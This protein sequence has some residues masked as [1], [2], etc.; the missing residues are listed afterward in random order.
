MCE[1]GGREQ[2]AALR[3]CDAAAGTGACECAGGIGVSVITLI[4]ILKNARRAV[5]LLACAFAC[6]YAFA[7]TTTSDQTVLVEKSTEEIPIPFPTKDNLPR[8]ISFDA[9]T[10]QEVQMI[11][12]DIYNHPQF[13][14]E[15]AGKVDLTRPNC[16]QWMFKKDIGKN[17][18]VPIGFFVNGNRGLLNI[19]GKLRK[20]NFAINFNPDSGNPGLEGGLD[21]WAFHYFKN[22]SDLAENYEKSS[23]VA[24]KNYL[25]NRNGKL[26]TI[27]LNNQI[28][29]VANKKMQCSLMDAKCRRYVTTLQS[30]EWYSSLPDKR[31]TLPI[32]GGDGFQIAIEDM[33]PW[34]KLGLVEINFRSRIWGE[35]NGVV[36][37]GFPKN[38]SLIKALESFVKPK[39]EQKK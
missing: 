25:D 8:T 15:R 20:L 2:R 24:M 21:V 39:I 9:L 13:A 1:R 17:A 37:H 34:R 36:R 38:P 33:C 31:V 18:W 30:I 11:R 4:P 10:D 7:Q 16:M 3:E 29:G 12:Q 6:T 28:L 22:Y 26:W 14:E 23:A 19:N 5:L 35:Q 32:S 27:E